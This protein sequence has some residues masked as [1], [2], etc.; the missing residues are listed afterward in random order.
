ME[1][2]TN[3]IWNA[4]LDT[5][6]TTNTVQ[7]STLPVEEPYNNFNAS[8][9]NTI[10]SY[11]VAIS[12]SDVA[13][14]PVSG[15][16]G[17]V[18]SFSRRS[19][20]SSNMVIQTAYFTDTNN[21]ADDI[22]WRYR[23]GTTGATDGWNPWI[24]L[25][26]ES[27]ILSL[28]TALTVLTGR[29]DTI[30]GSYF[31]A[32]GVKTF[33]D[34][35][36]GDH[37]E[38]PYDDFNTFPNNTV[39]AVGTRK[40]NFPAN[41]PVPNFRGTVLTFS[42]DTLVSNFS[43]QIAFDNGEDNVNEAIYWRKRYGDTWGA[44]IKFGDKQT[45]P[46]IELQLPSISGG[47][48]PTAY[49]VCNDINEGRN[50]S[51]AMWIDHLLTDS[52]ENSV[53]FMNKD[54]GFSS[55]R[56]KFIRIQPPASSDFLPQQTI[57]S[58][59]IDLDVQSKDFNI[60]NSAI[61]THRSSKASS[62]NTEFPKVLCI[63][64]SVTRGYLSEYNQFN[65]SLPKQYWSWIRWYF[66]KDKIDEGGT[67][68][69]NNY[70]SVGIYDAKNA[71]NIDYWGTRSSFTLN[72]QTIYNYAVGKGST[73]AANYFQES[74]NDNTLNPFYNPSLEN[75]ITHEN[76]TF[77]I[78]IFLDRFKTLD[79]DGTTRL[80]VG[81]TAGTEVSDSAAWDLCTP[82][83]IVINLNH[84][85]DR[86]TYDEYVSAMISNIKSRLGNDVVIIVA[87]IDVAAT[88]FPEKYQNYEPSDIAMSNSSALSRHRHDL[89]VYKYLKEEVEDEANNVYVFAGH[90]IQPTADSYPSNEMEVAEFA[91]TDR[92]TFYG[93]SL[94]SAPY[95]HPNNHAHSAWG[96]GLYAMIKWIYA[97][98]ASQQ[99]SQQE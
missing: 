64:D 89:S 12:A 57:K 10:V 59:N 43:L 49:T 39:I 94:G 20:S 45:L 80:V 17:T 60:S 2:F 51:P 52:T 92:D 3:N 73:T 54:I 16:K 34:N 72:G 47:P 32:S 67:S 68:S 7:I 23:F 87:T 79:N 71:Q 5:A 24:K 65:T 85:G 96:Y 4:V 93:K 88:Y 69:K 74:F 86:T 33:Y 9:F 98:K 13:N 81:S 26:K 1:G 56:H 75:P 84:N 53:D 40:L 70:L 91:G 11:S 21:H 28:Q 77:D 90:L 41:Q 99:E 35:I 61:I 44:W 95:G 30:E 66:E 58:E 82:T 37:S 15:F 62:T 25:T 19:D 46:N 83:H 31:K 50:I 36:T 48:L 78:Q 76:G 63:G 6:L 97:Y 14:V 55:G 29:I 38:A 18:V 27:D 42:Y 22:Y 8:P